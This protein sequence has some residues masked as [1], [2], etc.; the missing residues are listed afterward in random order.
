MRVSPAV[1]ELRARV[2]AVPR[3]AD[4]Q[5]GGRRDGRHDAQRRA[6]R[7]QLWALLDVE[8]RRARLGTRVTCRKLCGLQ[9]PTRREKMGSITTSNMPFD[10]FLCI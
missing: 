7:L 8:L 4:A 9:D 2:P 3:E 6:V 5:R 1:H 10:P